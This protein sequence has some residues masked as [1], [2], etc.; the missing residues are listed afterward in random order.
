KSDTIWCSYASPIVM[1]EN[2]AWASRVETLRTT[3]G[4]AT[5]V[6]DKAAGR[7]EVLEKKAKVFNK[8]TR[9]IRDMLDN[10]SDGA[11]RSDDCDPER[12]TFLTEYVK[13]GDVNVFK[14]STGQ[15]QMN[16]PDH[17]KLVIS[18]GGQMLRFIIN[19]KVHVFTREETQAGRINRFGIFLDEKVGE[20]VDFAAGVLAKWCRE[21]KVCGW[22]KK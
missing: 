9:Y 22:D 3:T 8:L 7:K 2:L 16:F 6:L 13:C 4:T 18:L 20:K 21:G 19:G 11:R 1:H 15:I 17:Q 5:E 10:S 14:M 12:E